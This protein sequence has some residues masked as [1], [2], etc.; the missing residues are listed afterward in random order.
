MLWIHPYFEDSSSLN[1]VKHVVKF[2]LVIHKLSSHLKFKNQTPS[3][4][5]MSPQKKNSTSVKHAI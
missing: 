3:Q 5:Y 2:N 1:N 4:M